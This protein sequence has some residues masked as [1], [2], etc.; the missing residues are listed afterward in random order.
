MAVAMVEETEMGVAMVEVAT[1]MV[2]EEVAETK[3]GTAVIA[4]EGAMAAVV[5]D[6]EV[7]VT[8]VGAVATTKTVGIRIRTVTPA[9]TGAAAEVTVVALVAVAAVATIKGVAVAMGVAGVAVAAVGV[10]VAMATSSRAVAT[11]NREV[12]SRDGASNRQDNNNNGD[13]KVNNSGDNNS[14]GHN[15]SMDSGMVRPQPLGLEQQQEQLTQ[16]KLRV[17]M[18]LMLLSGRPTGLNVN[19]MDSM[20][21]GHKVLRGQHRPGMALQDRQELEAP[22]DKKIDWI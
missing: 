21:N 5:E 18:P 15:N 9:R 12:S 17:T 1:S 20:V 13:N 19:S 14:N 16:P 3:V 10:V 2:V 6:T 8:E 11:A 4:E 22:S 7:V